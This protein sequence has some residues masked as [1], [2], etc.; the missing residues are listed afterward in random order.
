MS[1]H[2]ALFLERHGLSEPHCFSGV[3][4]GWIPILDDMVKELVSL[5]WDKD[6]QQVKEKFG[7][8]R[9]YVGQTTDEME[10]VIAVAEE[11]SRAVCEQCGAPG[12]L[13]TS[14]RH[15]WF[16]ACDPCAVLSKGRKHGT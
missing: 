14:T 5:G 9:V 12:E 7:I 10:S 11:R 4:K 1:D 3:G 8:L 15:W 16:T 13:N 2:F 6:L